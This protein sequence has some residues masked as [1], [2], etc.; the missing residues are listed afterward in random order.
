MSKTDGY[1]TAQ[2]NLWAGSFG[3][4]YIGRNES[5]ALLAPKLAILVDIFRRTSGIRS[6]LEFGANIGLNLIAARNAIPAARLK[7]VE[8]NE[9][10]FAELRQ[11]PGIE[12]HLGSVLEFDVPNAA[13]FVFTSALLIH[14]N[15][16]EIQR[17]YDVLHR[18]SRRYIAIIEYYHHEPIEITYKGQSGRLFKRDWAGDMLARFP[19]LALLDYGFVYRRDANFSIDDVHWF[20]LEKTVR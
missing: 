14:I 9:K 2:E 13:D 17:V 5:P 18:S 1:A 11:I 7:A 10:A 8:I 20:L 4:D 19:D 3:D 15:P 6:I 12:A 16:D